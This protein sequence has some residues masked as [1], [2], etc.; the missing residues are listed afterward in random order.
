MMGLCATLISVVLTLILLE[1]VLRFFPVR[2][3]ISY[4][5]VS[6]ENPVIRYTAHQTFIHSHHWD[7][8]DVNQGRTNA[9]GYVSDFDYDA[10]DTQPLIAV[11]GDSYIEA[12]MVAFADT[13]QEQIRKKLSNSTRVYGFG[14][15]GAPLSQYLAFAK[16]ARDT[17]HPD[18]MVFNIVS[19]DFDE[20]FPIYRNIPRF[21]YFIPDDTGTLHPQRLGDYTPSALKDFISG[22]ALVRY[23]Y[24]HLN[25]SNTVN[26]I[27]FNIRRVLSPTPDTYQSTSISD[28]TSADTSHTR[29]TLSEQGIDAFLTLLPEYTGLARKNILLVIDGQR[30]DIYAGT[31]PS[32]GYTRHMRETLIRQA[33]AQGFTVIDMHPLFE[34]DYAQ[35]KKPFEFAHDGHWNARAH[36]LAADA[37]LRSKPIKNLF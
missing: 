29:V 32:P 26:D 27:L 28:N 33:K 14:I 36:G 3:F 22:S 5:P 13:V 7:F 23:V 1:C 10:K 6:A 20:S 37:I 4:E 19:N 24:F 16:M 9:Q 8:Q 25:I 11:I 30:Y 2:S 35:H 12:R 18:M 34:K 21:H 15:G 17:Y 31:E